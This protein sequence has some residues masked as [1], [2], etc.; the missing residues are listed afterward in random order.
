VSYSRT[1]VTVS[2]ELQVAEHRSQSHGVFIDTVAV[3]SNNSVV[4][5]ELEQAKFGE[6]GSV[7]VLV[8]QPGGNLKALG[9]ELDSALAIREPDNRDF[10]LSPGYG[11]T[12]EGKG[13]GQTMPGL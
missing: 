1:S 10:A 2:N 9:E 3:D 4:V 13:L 6:D 5:I 7:D 8:D 11:A 12:V